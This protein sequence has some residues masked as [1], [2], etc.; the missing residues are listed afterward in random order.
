MNEMNPYK[1]YASMGNLPSG[2]SVSDFYVYV[3]DRKM[4]LLS[5]LSLLNLVW[6]TR[7]LALVQNL[8]W[9][10]LLRWLLKIAILLQFQ[11]ASMSC[12]DDAYL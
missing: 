8:L 10:T 12:H 9:E 1:S 3:Q 5:L 6:K 4:F 11:A 2:M 7:K